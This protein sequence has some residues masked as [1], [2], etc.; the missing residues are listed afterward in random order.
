MFAGALT[1]P[2]MTNS[3]PKLD[4]NFASALLRRIAIVI[5]DRPPRAESHT[6]KV[7]RAA[8][9]ILAGPRTEG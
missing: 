5:T 9:K 7:L 2:E 8:K 4:S 1:S 6:L 3:I